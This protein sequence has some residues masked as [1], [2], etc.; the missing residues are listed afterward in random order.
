M[1]SR[2]R[3]TL[4]PLGVAAMLL[5]ALPTAHAEQGPLRADVAR[6]VDVMQLE[7]N[8]TRQ[9]RSLLDQFDQ[10]LMSGPALPD[11][12]LRM[13]R[14]AAADAWSAERLLDAQV[15]ALQE[16][17]SPA[18]VARLT[19]DYLSPFGQRQLAEEAAHDPH[20]DA[21]DFALFVARFEQSEEHAERSAV[22]EGFIDDLDMVDRLAQVAMDTQVAMLSGLVAVHDVPQAEA[23]AFLAHARTQTPLLRTQLQSVVPALLAWTYEN[24]T[25]AELH[26][27]DAQVRSEDG[28]LHLDATFAGIRQGMVYGSLAFS[29]N[30]AAATRH[31]ELMDEI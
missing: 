20:R 21:D 2:L 8:A 27:I 9:S 24:L 12:H 29:D 1:L 18:V 30:L 31:A 16:A 5:I 4:A 7:R 22:L 17:L 13:L 19:D 23:D 14:D 10:G 28:R 15:Q 3:H 11:D 25:L 6:L 26:R